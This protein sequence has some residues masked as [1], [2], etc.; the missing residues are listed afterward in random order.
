[1]RPRSDIQR[2]RCSNSVHRFLWA[3]GSSI[4]LL[5]CSIDDPDSF[6]DANW[7][8][9]RSVE[10]HPTNSMRVL[11][12][13]KCDLPQERQTLTQQQIMD[14]AWEYRA[15]VH[16]TCTE[17]EPNFPGAKPILETLSDIVNLK[18][19]IWDVANSSMV[20]VKNAAVWDAVAGRC[21][22]IIIEPQQGFSGSLQH[23]EP[24]KELV[25]KHE[26]LESIQNVD[27]YHVRICSSD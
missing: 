24:F 14:K 5:V 3:V 15:H 22:R 18:L 1:V 20:S 25:S 21:L 13:N 26:D 17:G 7:P 8:T 10:I 2:F 6:E 4:T 23:Y 11:L 12:V 27:I 16:Y 19:K 9:Q